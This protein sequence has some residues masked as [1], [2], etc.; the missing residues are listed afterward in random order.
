MKRKSK[1]AS[2]VRPANF[3]AIAHDLCL[4]TVSYLNKS[5]ECDDGVSRWIPRDLIGE[6]GKSLVIYRTADRE[7]AIDG[8]EPWHDGMFGGRHES[9]LS[10]LHWI[11]TAMGVRAGTITDFR[12]A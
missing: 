2:V 5:L 11:K 1:A 9:I 6:D 12:G 7:Y 8:W 4:R 10:A 3:Q